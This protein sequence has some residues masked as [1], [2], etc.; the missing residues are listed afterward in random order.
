M[1]EIPTVDGVPVA[2]PPPPGYEVDFENPQRNSVIE[3]YC[4][5]GVGNFFCLLF[6]MQRAYVKLVLQKRV[7][8]EDGKSPSLRIRPGLDK[9][10]SLTLGC[11]LIAWV[12]LLASSA[13]ES[14]S[15]QPPTD[16]FC[17]SVITHHS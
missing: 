2:I 1:A 9:I 11:L 13:R 12:R 17:H 6:M 8:V 16:L 4:I 5:F 3:A 7:Q 14:V 15:D 10:N